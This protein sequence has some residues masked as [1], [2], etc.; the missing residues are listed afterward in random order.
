MN[1]PPIKETRFQRCVSQLAVDKAMKLKI[2]AA[3]VSF[4]LLTAC[5]GGGSDTGTVGA[6]PDLNPIVN[7]RDNSTPPPPTTA[8]DRTRPAS[9]VFSSDG[10]TL[11]SN[12]ADL[13]SDTGAQTVSPDRVAAW[14]GLRYGNFLVS[15]NPWNASA[16]TYPLWFQ[17]I[18]L[19]DTDNGYGVA[20]EWDWGSEGD[21]RG[22][23][24]NTKAYPEVIYGTKSAG[25]RSGT[26]AETGLPV[27]IFDAPA[28]TI[29]YSFW[30]EGRRS[31]SA[32]PGGT[33]S[34]FNIAIESFFHDSCDIQRTGQESDNTIF[35]MMVW[36][37]IDDREPAGGGPIDVVTTS[38]G[39]LYNVYTKVAGLQ[40]T[41][42][43]DYIAFVAQDE[44]FSGTVMYSELL[45]IAR[46]RADEFNL[47]RLSDTDCLANILMGTEIWHG[48]GTFNL[49]EYTI[50]RSY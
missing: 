20:Y 28:F 38:D 25:E 29:D 14:P 39:R 2:S 16:A 45:N 30:Y 18:S 12:G 6:T 19:Y 17:D 34:E 42:V 44:N 37:K 26:F 13:F 23:V 49:N 32:T 48:A 27:E 11:K 40:N 21:T 33:D 46:D 7:N 41:G 22:S 4:A 47:Y 35:E 31:S 36:L 3:M 10:S 15:N 50:H 43:Q 1:T 24:F 8:E 5:G 9:G